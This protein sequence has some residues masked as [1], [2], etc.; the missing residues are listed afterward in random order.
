MTDLVERYNRER[1]EDIDKT[2]LPVTL[3]DAWNLSPHNRIVFYCPACKAKV[4]ADI[5]SSYGPQDEIGYECEVCGAIMRLALEWVVEPD[6]ID[7]EISLI[8][9]R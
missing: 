4:A 6:L 1:N 2:D 8:E 5:D 3:S 9:Q 7:V